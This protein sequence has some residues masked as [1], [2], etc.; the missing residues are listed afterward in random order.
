V[1]LIVKVSSVSGIHVPSLKDV[2][3]LVAQAITKSDLNE[4]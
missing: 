4:E 1:H 2:E 3:Q